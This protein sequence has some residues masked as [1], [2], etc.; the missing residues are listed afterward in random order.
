[1]RAELDSGLDDAR[2]R[3]IAKPSGWN[4]TDLYRATRLVLAKRL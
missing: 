3:P 2:V 1:M 4:F